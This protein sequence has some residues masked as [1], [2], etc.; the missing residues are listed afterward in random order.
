METW[1]PIIE[2]PRNLLKLCLQRCSQARMVEHSENTEEEELFVKRKRY[3]EWSK[4]KIGE[5]IL[6]Y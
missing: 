2:P 5:I 1:S 4:S 6:L 3:N